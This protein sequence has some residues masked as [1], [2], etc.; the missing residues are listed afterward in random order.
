VFVLPPWKKMTFVPL[1]KAVAQTIR[2]IVITRAFL[3]HL[4]M[5]ISGESQPPLIRE[6]QL[7]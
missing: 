6:L 1:A 4:T 7:T 3:M 5:C 2:A